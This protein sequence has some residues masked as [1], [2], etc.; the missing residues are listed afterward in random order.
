MSENQGNDPDWREVDPEMAR[1][2]LVQGETYLKAQ[3]DISLASDRRALTVGSIFATVAIGTAG[4]A[5]ARFAEHKGV[6]FLLAGLSTATFL[7]LGAWW[8]FWSARPI[9]FYSPGSHPKQWWPVRKAPLA[10]VIGGE[11]ENYQKY[12]EH[13]ERCLAENAKALERGSRFAATAPVVGL[14]VWLVSL[15]LFPS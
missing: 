11:T 10:E 8:C 5:I 7:V 4:A 9:L 12:I 3:L 13:N 14:I 2:V 1:T 6:P 15:Y